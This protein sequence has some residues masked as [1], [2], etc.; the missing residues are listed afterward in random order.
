MTLTGESAMTAAAI[1]GENSRPKTDTKRPLQSA[2]RRIVD[3]GKK[4]FWRMSHAYDPAVH[5]E[6]DEKARQQGQ[7]LEHAN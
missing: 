4:R 2:P 6:V 3:K 7:P 1:I 5:E